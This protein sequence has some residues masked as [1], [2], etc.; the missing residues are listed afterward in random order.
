MFEE[1]EQAM[2]GAEEEDIEET[3]WKGR[4]PD[5]IGHS[6]YD[7]W[8]FTRVAD[9]RRVT[10]LQNRTRRSRDGNYRPDFRVLYTAR[11]QTLHQALKLHHRKHPKTEVFARLVHRCDKLL[12]NRLL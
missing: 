5:G 4:G 11:K 12:V 1:E 2:E 3:L 7:H 10:I 6:R 8:R 9:F